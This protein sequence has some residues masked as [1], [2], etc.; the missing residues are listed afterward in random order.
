MLEE[1]PTRPGRF[2]AL[3][4]THYVSRLPN[5]PRI[6]KTTKMR[7]RLTF[8]FAVFRPFS[9]NILLAGRPVNPGGAHDRRRAGDCPGTARPTGRIPLLAGFLGWRISL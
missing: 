7:K 4:F 2:H 1:R 5:L 8:S 6:Q 3:R 9:H